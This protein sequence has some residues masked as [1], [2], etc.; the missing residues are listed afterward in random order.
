MVSPWAPHASRLDSAFLNCY[1]VWLGPGCRREIHFDARV[2]FVNVLVEMGF[3]DAVIVDA[4]S[5]TESILCDLESAIDI[6]S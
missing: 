2:V 6:P 5:L 3:N 4:E 1:T